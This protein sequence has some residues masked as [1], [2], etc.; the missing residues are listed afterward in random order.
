M[1]NGYGKMHIF[2]QKYPKSPSHTYKVKGFT[3]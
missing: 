2:L 3:G 1:P